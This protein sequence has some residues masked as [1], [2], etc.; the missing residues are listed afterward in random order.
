VGVEKPQGD[1]NSAVK[2]NG[3]VQFH[4]AHNLG[5]RIHSVIPDFLQS[6]PV[7]AQSDPLQSAV[8]ASFGD[9]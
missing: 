6:P 9:A 8:R 3:T 7:S 2:K 5:E 4:A 1:E